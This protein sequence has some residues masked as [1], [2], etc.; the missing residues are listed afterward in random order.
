M[1]NY[2]QKS[3]DLGNPVKCLWGISYLA[4]SDDFRDA[5]AERASLIK[6]SGCWQA[7]DYQR[8]LVSSSRPDL[9]L[10][11]L[12][13][14]KRRCTSKIRTH[15]RNARTLVETLRRVAVSHRFIP[16]AL[17]YFGN[18]LI[19]HSG[20]SACFPFDRYSSGAYGDLYDWTGREY[21][22]KVCEVGALNCMRKLD[23][24]EY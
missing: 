6:C 9:S 18:N 21:A 7:R 8:K 3:V 15:G 17:V 2:Y 11:L 24:C 4:S 20:T 22:R 23:E 5:I 19:F 13:N 16:L 10:C 12:A 1:K 14:T